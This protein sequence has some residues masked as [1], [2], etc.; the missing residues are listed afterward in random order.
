[1]NINKDESLKSLKLGMVKARFTLGKRMGMYEKIASFLDS[2]FDLV[3]TLTA[4]RDRYVL[5]KDSRAVILSDWLRVLAQGGRF[6]DAIA[7]WVPAA[8][9]MLIESGDRSGDLKS[10]LREAVVLSSSARKSQAAIF[11]GVAFP[12]VLF[13]MVIAILC[14]FQARM[15]PIF[16]ELLPIA[17]WPESAQMLNFIS[18]FLYN[19]LFFILI[20]FGII[21]FIIGKTMGSWTAPPRN[22]FDKLPPWNI[23]KSYQGSSFLIALSSLLRAG[24]PAYNAL[25]A[26]YRNASPWMRIHLS[27]MMVT[28]NMGGG[29][30]GRALDTGLLDDE[31]A[32][33]IQDYARLGNFA[34]AI[35]VFGAKSLEKGVQD[36]QFRMNIIKNLLLVVVAL[37][38]LWMYYV[39]FMLQQVIADSMGSGM[40]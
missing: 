30:V 33:E 5:R 17:K 6:P 32:G 16:S 28:M 3:S 1:M 20:A 27:K 25:R 23:Y 14:L 39:S 11:G 18:G 26:I 13:A 19:N 4:I 31:T 15:V 10:G 7:P 22:I 29:N 38:I 35:Y 12:S 21:A 24:V 2:D 8:E 37:I 36:I 9:L 34:E 40:N